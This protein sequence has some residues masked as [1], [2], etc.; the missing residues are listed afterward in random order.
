MGRAET[1]SAPNEQP[2]DSVDKAHRWKSATRG[3][4]LRVFLEEEGKKRERDSQFTKGN[5]KRDTKEQVKRTE[6][7]DR[8]KDH[9]QD[10]KWHRK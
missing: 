8:K 3:I 10:R 5:K 2:D 4:R 6:K 7:K 9:R 1:P